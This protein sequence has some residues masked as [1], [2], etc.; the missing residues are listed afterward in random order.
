MRL[1][2]RKSQ[3]LKR[4]DESAPL[5]LTAD[6]IQRLETEL[7]RLKRID[8]PQAVQD[9]SRFGELGDRSENAEYQEAK[10]RLTRIDGRI[11]SLTERLKRA[12]PITHTSSNTV[13]LGSTVVIRRHDK[14]TT[15]LIVG[16][17]EAHPAK[18]RLSHLSPLGSALLG[19]SVGD[20]VR[21]ETPVETSICRI[22]QIR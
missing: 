10:F 4:T 14:E 2:Q 17:Q 3:L 1:P 9:F 7:D 22:I 13:K 15:Y 19:R 11:F 8:R 21:F 18:G 16:Q 20:E 12:I 5:Y 6:G